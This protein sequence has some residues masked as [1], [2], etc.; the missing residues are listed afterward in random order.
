MTLHPLIAALALLLVANPSSAQTEHKHPPATQ[1][2]HSA[3]PTAAT[4]LTEG[5]VRKLD[6]EQGKITLRHGPITH[7]DMPGMTMVFKA[8]ESSLLTGLQV[9]QRVRFA[10]EKINGVL[11][12]T[13]IHP[14]QAE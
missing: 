12:V 11:T 3:H 9:G 13:A 2:D 7:L 5:E 14:Q 4:A 1:A 10:A 6:T 8:S